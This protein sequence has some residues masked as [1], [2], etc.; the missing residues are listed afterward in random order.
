MSNYSVYP[1]QQMILFPREGNRN[2]RA[3]H[4]IFLESH[5]RINKFHFVTCF[6]NRNIITAIFPLLTY[7]RRNPKNC[8]IKEKYNFGNALN[9]VDKKIPSFN[10]SQ[11]M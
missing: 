2:F 10:M 4:S 8:R 7:E 11:L 5:K 9:K 1:V 3:P 6:S